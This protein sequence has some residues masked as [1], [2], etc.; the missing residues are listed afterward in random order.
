MRVNDVTW[1]VINN[2]WYWYLN[3]NANNGDNNDKLE[4]WWNMSPHS[5]P[6]QKRSKK[7]HVP[8]WTKASTA[9]GAAWPERFRHADTFRL[10]K[11][12]SKR[13]SA[14]NNDE[15]FGFGGTPQSKPLC[16][17]EDTLI[18]EGLVV[19]NHDGT[20]AKF[21]T[22]NEEKSSVMAPCRT[23]KVDFSKKK[24]Q[25][26]NHQKNKSTGRITRRNKKKTKKQKNKN[27]GKCRFFLFVSCF[28]LGFGFLVCFF[29]LLWFFLSN[30]IF[31]VLLDS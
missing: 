22:L 27:C 11:V 1:L 24:K 21:I 23:E 14:E 15:P 6:Q 30:P 31:S 7:T 4:T 5:K 18:A 3:N 16:R 17:I 26:H 28:F 9:T 20:S 19:F 2:G 29:C 25:K 8:C 12:Y 13:Q 10:A